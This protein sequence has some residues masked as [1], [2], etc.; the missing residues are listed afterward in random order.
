MFSGQKGNKIRFVIKSEKMY[1]WYST[2]DPNSQKE[3]KS[4]YVDDQV[5]WGT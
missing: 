1:W 3:V 5:S 2:E 4:P